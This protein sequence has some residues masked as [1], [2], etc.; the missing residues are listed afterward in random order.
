MFGKQTKQ[1]C[2]ALKQENS[3]LKQRIS[4]L[5]V[6]LRAHCEDCSISKNLET[7]ISENKL[8]TGLTLE[9]LQGCKESIRKIQKNIEN[10]LEASEEISALSKDNSKD[11]SNLNEISNQLLE[12]ISTIA[13][14]SM[15]SRTIAE[16]LHQSVDE[17]SSVINLIKDI[18]DQTN[19]LALN[20]AIEAARAGEHGRGF[21][22]VA[23]E[24]RKLAERTQKATQEVE[25][26]IGILKQN[27]TSMFEQSEQIGALSHKS[28]EFIETF[29]D[30][31]EKIIDKTSLIEKDSQEITFAIFATLAK[32]DHVLFKVEGYGS[33]YDTK[34][35]QL[36]N[37]TNCRLGKWYADIG[38]RNFER[39]KSYR[40][41]EEPHKIVHDSINHAIKCVH[42]GTCLNDINIVINAFIKAENSSKE[43]FDLLDDMLKEKLSEH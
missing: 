13:E 42:D 10:N 37:H 23:D 27:S 32:L 25:T 21:A 30:E 6:E 24:V 39:T 41:L 31:F 11:I 40:L 4:E 17:I 8:K 2:E 1:E 33:I 5:E 12:I 14:S 34:H 15:N 35:E 22:V 9:M 38:K 3:A 36:S 7:T 29:K 18:S 28:N 20:A 26:N 16:N 43:L 19:L